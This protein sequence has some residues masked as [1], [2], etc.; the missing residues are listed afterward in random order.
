MK[1][2]KI[3]QRRLVLEKDTVV[4]LRSKELQAVNGGNPTFATCPFTIRTCASFEF[5]C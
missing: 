1:K 5:S 2:S 3:A 4:V